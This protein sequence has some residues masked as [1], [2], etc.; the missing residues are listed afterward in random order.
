MEISN[1]TS[2]RFGILKIS[3]RFFREINLSQIKKGS[4]EPVVRYSSKISNVL[5]VGIFGLN[6]L[7][8]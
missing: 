4:P 3:I 5:D 8:A 1:N 7:L 6:F 2:N